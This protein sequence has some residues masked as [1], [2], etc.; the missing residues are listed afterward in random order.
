MTGG[1]P[2]LGDRLFAGDGMGVLPSAPTEDHPRYERR[3]PQ[4]GEVVSPSRQANVCVTILFALEMG[5][6]P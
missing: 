1:R 3:T 2:G 5:F 6:S 4:W